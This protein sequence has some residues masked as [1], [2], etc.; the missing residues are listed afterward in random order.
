M[1]TKLSLISIILCC[2]LIGTVSAQ[3][4]AFRVLASKGANSVDAKN[5]RIGS[6]I[7]ANQSIKVGSQSYL[8][9][10]HKSGKTLELK[11]AGTYKVADLVAKLSAAKSG[12]TSKYIDF[13]TSELTQ[14]PDKN[15]MARRYKH[16]SKTG[17]V[18][19][20]VGLDPIDLMLEKRHNVL[21]NEV[22][23]LWY[24]NEKLPIVNPEG[25]TGYKVTI[26]NLFGEVLEEKTL[27]ASETMLILSLDDDK[28]KNQN[29][30]TYKVL[31]LG[32]NSMKSSE[33]VLVKMTDEKIKGNY[34]D[35]DILAQ[36]N[37]ALGKIILAKYL[38]EQLLIPEA[39][40]AYHDALEIE[41]DVEAYQTLYNEFMTR[42]ELSKEA[43]LASQN[44]G[45]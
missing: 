22:A 4:M 20:K 10:A 30:I 36:N 28:F 38:E 5:L 8:G 19:R 34:A 3:E 26:S 27:K 21:G 39:M 37:T 31:A 45:K 13:V 17:A 23:I 18:E 2:L 32:E 7:T 6:K 41:S 35:Y 24:L 1:K 9:L 15:A 44:E 11:E 29:E 33:Q 40:A 14:K 16:M 43:Y 12:V 25:V 42:T